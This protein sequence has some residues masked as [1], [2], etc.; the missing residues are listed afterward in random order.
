MSLEATAWLIVYSG[1][2]EQHLD[3]YAPS[4][5]AV[6]QRMCIRL[7]QASACLYVFVVVRALVQVRGAT[8]ITMTTVG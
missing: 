1:L 4:A 5:R 3:A 6:G 8:I 2:E 7:L